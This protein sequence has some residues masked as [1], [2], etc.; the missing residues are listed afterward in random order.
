MEANILDTRR[1]AI[2]A[3]IVISK[4]RAKVYVLTQTA[5]ASI[6]CEY[7]SREIRP[8]SN[9][10]DFLVGLAKVTGVDESKRNEKK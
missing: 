4:P 9:N 7:F 10:T 1:T 2:I 8:C 3:V 5:N 6:F